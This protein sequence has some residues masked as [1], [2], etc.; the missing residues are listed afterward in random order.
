MS[1]HTSIRGGLPVSSQQEAIIEHILQQ[2]VTVVAAGAG[3]GK[4]HTTVAAVVELVEQGRATPDQFVLITFTNKAADELRARIEEVIRRRYD[5][6]STSDEKIF[7]H[8]HLERLGAS[9]IGTIHGFCRS[10]IRTYGFDADAA[11]TSDVTFASNFLKEALYD[12]LED[13]T[14]HNPNRS[15]LAPGQSLATYELIKLLSRILDEIRNRGYASATVLDQTINQ[16]QDAGYPYRKAVATLV[17]RAAEAYE[18]IKKREH[19]LDSNDLLERV[20]TL[21]TSDHATHII[22]RVASRY[23]YLFVDEYQDTDATQTNLVLALLPHL[24]GVL[25]VGD[26]KQSIYGWRGAEPGLLERFAEQNGT[27]VLPMN[28]SRRPTL[29]LL[30]VQNALFFDSIGNVFPDLKERLEAAD[31]PYT[32][33]HSLP[34]LIHLEIPNPANDVAGRVIATTGLLNALLGYSVQLKAD[35]EAEPLQWGHII[36]LCRT[37]RLVQTYTNGLQAAG[38]PARA[39][40]GSS[41]YTRPE[42]ISTYRML[43]VLLHYPD[44]TTLALALSTPYFR[45]V[46]SLDAHKE[47]RRLVQLRPEEGTPLLD[48]LEGNYPHYAEALTEL[49]GAVRTE[50]VPQL[51]ARLYDAFGLISY[52]AERGDLEAV[53]NLEQLR[54]KA[55]ELVQNEQALSL[56]AFTSWLQQAIEMERE[57]RDTGS[58]EQG[59]DVPPYIRV[60]TIHRAKGLQFPVVVVPEIMHDLREEY[61]EPEFLILENHGLEVQI[62]GLQ[63]TSPRYSTEVRRHQDQQVEEQMRV[64][65]V[66]LTRAQNTLIT[67]GQQGVSAKLSTHSRYSWLDEIIRAR[68]ALQ[69]LGAVYGSHA[70]ISAQLNRNTN[71]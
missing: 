39:D 5:Q 64:L 31:N 19:Q 66:A 61:R 53:Q 56:R 29:P 48:W 14:K 18:A 36:V 13:Y 51:M 62:E 68:T 45:D 12:V 15:L 44:D 40:T 54:A 71:T 58:A 41:P 37:N 50:T 23:R 7:W 49:R 30:S 69:A 47:R 3:S 34:P 43:R 28:V 1:K 52:Y 67:I 46:D 17:D 60:L 32:P 59:P 65:Y 35:T 70:V 9:Y 20:V 2:N 21:L 22:E 63:T 33:V 57:E 10:L 16:E 8:N 11:R 6:A 27:Q 38:I 55:R 42:V 4:T 25:V 26:R 24:A